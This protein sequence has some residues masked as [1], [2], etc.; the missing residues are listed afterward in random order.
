MPRKPAHQQGD[1]LKLIQDRAFV[2]FG[3]NGYEGVSIGDL[4]K[5]TGLS[6][7]A[8]YWHYRGKEA[9]F[10]DCLKKLHDIFDEHI[11]DPMRTHNQGVMRILL[12]FRGLEKLA[13]D[14]RIAEGV[15]GYWL[16]PSNPET[17]MFI[18]AQRAFE[19][20]ARDT[21]EHTL[22]LGVEQ[23][24]FDYKG[25]LEDMARAIIS[26]VEAVILPIRY[27]NQAEVHSIIGVLARTLFR[28]Y[29]KPEHVP[30]VDHF[31][32]GAA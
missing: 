23:G 30:Q 7:G 27:L 26:L 4:A 17:Q 24:H 15:A 22:R 19:T 12:M 32:S 18:Q 14:P 1:T 13:A 6:K 29:A 28:A 25:D 5:E 16:I 8:L 3:R 20:R 21:L 9:L 31:L 11:F 10:L 2:L